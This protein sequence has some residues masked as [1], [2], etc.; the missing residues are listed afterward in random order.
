MVPSISEKIIFVSSKL[1][2]N[3]LASIVYYPCNSE[4]IEYVILFMPIFRL[5]DFNILLSGLI[6]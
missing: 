3:I 2:K 1:Y 5:K 4:L 6:E